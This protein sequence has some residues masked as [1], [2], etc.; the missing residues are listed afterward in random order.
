MWV[1]KMSRDYDAGC[2]YHKD[3][4][5]HAI[6]GYAADYG[7]PHRCYIYECPENGKMW[8]VKEVEIEL[9]TVGGNKMS[10]ERAAKEA[11]AKI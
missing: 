2:I 4:R 10:F 8:L 7:G 9:S 3:G 5:S 11:Y 1:I 6:C